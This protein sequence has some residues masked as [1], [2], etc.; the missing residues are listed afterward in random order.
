[1]T[2]LC[3]LQVDVLQGFLVY[4]LGEDLL[5]AVYIVEKHLGCFNVIIMYCQAQV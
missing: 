5:W 3:G 2:I 4:E 1:M